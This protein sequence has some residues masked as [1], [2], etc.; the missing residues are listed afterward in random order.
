M[1][2]VFL[3]SLLGLFWGGSYVAIKYVVAAFPPFTGA[4]LRVIVALAG[5]LNGTVPLWTFLRGAAVV[6]AGVLLLH[7][8]EARS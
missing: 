7:A 5:L 4:A 6:L 8:E 3:F 2:D 1:T